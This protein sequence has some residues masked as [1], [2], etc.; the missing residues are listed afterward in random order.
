MLFGGTTRSLCFT[1]CAASGG[2]RCCWG[3]SA[4]YFSWACQAPD[5]S[6]SADQV[7]RH[8]EDGVPGARASRGA[9]AQSFRDVH[10]GMGG[11]SSS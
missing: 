6:G 11:D 5:L 2:V 9:A 10:P 4:P 7:R 1:S 8:D 3:E